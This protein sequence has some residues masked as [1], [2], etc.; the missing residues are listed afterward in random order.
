M[1]DLFLFPADTFDAQGD[2]LKMNL[3][4]LRTL[5]P[6]P[7]RLFHESLKRMTSLE[8]GRKDSTKAMHFRN[9]KSLGVK[10]KKEK[11]Q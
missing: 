3:S 8:N 6:D 1:I 5:H 2:V 9:S 10:K 7:R 4:A 11:N